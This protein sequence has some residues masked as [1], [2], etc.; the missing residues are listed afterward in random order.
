MPG[1]HVVEEPGVSHLPIIHH[2]RMIVVKLY[3]L[4]NVTKSLN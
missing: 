4:A 1:G 3:A 2:M